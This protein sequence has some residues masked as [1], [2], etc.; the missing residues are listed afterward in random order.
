MTKSKYL[1]TRVTNQNCI[2]EEI[3]EQIIGLG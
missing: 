3:T 2:L 1:G